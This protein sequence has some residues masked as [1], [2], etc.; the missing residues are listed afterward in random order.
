MKCYLRK[1]EV[2]FQKLF[3]GN[4]YLF[5]FLLDGVTLHMTTCKGR[6]IFGQERKEGRKNEEEKEKKCKVWS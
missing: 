4:V 2:L 3:C 5:V 1:V 6:L